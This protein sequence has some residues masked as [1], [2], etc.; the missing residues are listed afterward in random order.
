MGTSNAASTMAAIANR[1]MRPP[2]TMSASWPND[3]S[4]SMTDS[5]Q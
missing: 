5:V 2:M 3:S 4:V 1:A